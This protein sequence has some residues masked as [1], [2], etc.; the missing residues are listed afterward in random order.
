[1]KSISRD[2]LFLFGAG[3]A[4]II[5]VLGADTNFADLFHAILVRL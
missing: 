3:I 1:M 2:T 4:A 5:A